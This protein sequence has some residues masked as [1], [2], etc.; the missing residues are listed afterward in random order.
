IGG[1]DRYIIEQLGRVK[2]PVF[3]VVNKID[4]IDPEAVLNKI[5]Q[6]KDLYPFAEVVP[7]SAM[8]GNNITTLLDQISKYLPEGP[9]YDPADQVTDHPGQFVGAELIGEKILHLRVKKFLIPL[10]FRLRI[11]A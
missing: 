6:Y 2:T 1:G 9:Q 5:I 11:C 3:L 10:Q 8:N 7:I 4:K